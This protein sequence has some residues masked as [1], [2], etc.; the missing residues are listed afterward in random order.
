LTDPD[1]ALPTH[2]MNWLRDRLPD[3]FQ[4]FDISQSLRDAAS[5]VAS[6]VAGSLGALVKNLFSFFVALFILIFALFFVFRDGEQIVRGVRHLLPF[7]A[8]IQRD[9][10]SES[11]ELIFASV[12]VALVIAIL[13]GAL[14]S[15]AF[16]IGGVPTPILWGVM[17]AFFSLIPVVGSALIWV[18]AA[19]W[20]GLSGH[21]GRA[22]TVI[23]ICGGVAGVA[24]NIIRPLLLR[25]RTHLNELLLFISVL[26]GL[27]VFG[28]LG[29][30]AG[31]TIVAA[32]MG[33]FRVYMDRR[34]EIGASS[35]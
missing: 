9:M 22:V 32:A 4:S 5:K 6:F 30:V 27:Q 1:K 19:I 35:G 31:P 7:D 26:G 16:A 23:A 10:L 8:S 17:I 12:A 29:L 15:I 25:N 11:R 13:Q 3:E 33:V 20:L 14:G 28:L 24:D 2:A 21:W 18:P 34:D